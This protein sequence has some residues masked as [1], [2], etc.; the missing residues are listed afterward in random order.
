MSKILISTLLLIVC[1]GIGAPS[2]AAKN[3]ECLKENRVVIL[4]ALDNGALAFLC[5]RVFD[6]SPYSNIWDYCRVKGDLVYLSE[7]H[8]YADSQRI[9]LP[10]G[11]CFASGGVYKY[12]NREGHGKT[13]RE[14][15]IMDSRTPRY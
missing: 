11:Y 12:T 3:R 8:N 13:V 1:I 15:Y 10:R 4:Q 7:N 6:T 9:T 5:P 2:E 14:I